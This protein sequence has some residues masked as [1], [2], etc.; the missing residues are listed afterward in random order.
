MI[1]GTGILAKAAAKA[2]I[3][4]PKDHSSEN[5]DKEKYAR[6][7]IYLAVQ[8]GRPLPYP[9]AHWDN[10]EVIASI[11]EDQLKT[12]TVADLKKLGLAEGPSCC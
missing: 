2:G 1:V 12:V 3:E 10:A 6:W 4:V 7:H 9:S 5:F 11:P 8:L